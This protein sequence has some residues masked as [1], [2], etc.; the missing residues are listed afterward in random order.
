M[1]S[2][3]TRPM[4]ADEFLVYP[5]EPGTRHEL[6][7]G[8]VRSLELPGGKHGRV[9]LKAGR[10][11]GNFVESRMLG[12]S[13]AAE[14]GFVIERDPDTVRAPDVSFV[15]VDRLPE[16]L[17]D[18]KFLPFAP[19]LAVEVASPTDRPGEI[20][21]KTDRWLTAGTRMVWNL[22]PRSA[23]ATIHRPGTPPVTLSAEDEIDGGD[24]L[25]GFRCCVGELFV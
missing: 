22:Y 9:A 18:E 12:Y 23:T 10:L 24:V 19:D 21:E 1:S 4:T 11:I 14:T 20:A 3:S 2:I 6:V 15:R 8:E 25:P 16:V 7:R 13:Y 17:D 5:F